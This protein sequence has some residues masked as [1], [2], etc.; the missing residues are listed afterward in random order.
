MKVKLAWWWNKL[1]YPRKGSLTGRCYWVWN[2]RLYILS[3]LYLLTAECQTTAW[4]DWSACSA[5]CGSGIR[6]R[7]RNYISTPKAR[8]SNCAVTLVEKSPCETD[9][10]GD[11]SCATTAWSEWSE[12][13][14]TCG[15]GYRTRTRLFANHMARRLCS[16]VPLVETEGCIGMVPECGET[17]LD[18][19]DPRCIVTEW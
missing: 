10:V 13:P 12:C 2:N 3:S 8:G 19:I 7:T 5:T 16:Q 1:L 11:V 14:V 15:R 9:C 18:T 4:S 6:I 17:N